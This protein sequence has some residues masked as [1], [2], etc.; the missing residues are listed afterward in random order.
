MKG[1]SFVLF[2]TVKLMMVGGNQGETQHGSSAHGDGI[3]KRNS[4]GSLKPS[5]FL[6]YTGGGKYVKDADCQIR[7]RITNRVGNL[8]ALLLQL[9]VV[10]FM[11]LVSRVIIFA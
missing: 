7:R 4:V 5:G 2:N 10:G 6:H 3:G 9:F 8:L 1:D 11:Y